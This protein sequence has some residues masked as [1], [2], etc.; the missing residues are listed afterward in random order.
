MPRSW[1]AT[2]RSSWR[3]LL[4]EVSAFGVV[5]AVNVLVDLLVFQLV[6][7]GLGASPIGAK[8]ASTAVSTTSAYFMHRHWSF[9][10]RARTSLRREYLLFFAINAVTLLLALGVVTVV[11]NGFGVTAALPLQIANLASIA[12]GTVIRFVAYKRWVFL[13]EPATEAPTDHRPAPPDRRDV[14]PVSR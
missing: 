12:L 7:V 2:L 14:A 8:I 13:A 6:Y 3:V 11:H 1:T 5:G 9:S 4:K 10:H